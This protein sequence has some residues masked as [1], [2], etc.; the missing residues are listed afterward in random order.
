MTLQSSGQIALSDIQTEYSR[1]DPNL[2][3]YYG[4]STGIPTSGRI[5]IKDFYG[6]SSV[7]PF[8][9]VL[10]DNLLANKQTLLEPDTLNWLKTP[11]TKINA[12]WDIKIDGI[13]CQAA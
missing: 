5:G 2:K 4:A 8:D 13:W 6:A 11:I 9:G 12:Q 3:A 10:I 7:P 1:T